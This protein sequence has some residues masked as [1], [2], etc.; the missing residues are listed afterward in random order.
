[1]ISSL[2]P[3]LRRHLAVHRHRYRGTSWYVVE[4]KASGRVH[5][6][7]PA[8][9]LLVGQMNGRRTVDDI[10]NYVVT[11]LGDDAPSQGEV[12]RLLSQLNAMDLLQTDIAPNPVE[13]TERFTK[14]RRARLRGSVGNP[15][16]LKLPLWDPDR[17]LE[18]SYPLVRPIF[19]G[20]GAALWILVTVPALILVAMH[21]SQL[22]E[23]ISDRVF[24]ME[25]LVLAAN[26]FPLLKLLHELGHGYATKIG[27]GEVHEL[28]VMFL[29]F[30]PIP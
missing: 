17:F 29:V 28:G 23:N 1:R 13:M 22:T 3:R 25:S 18:R 8:V 14:H 27:G 19:T 7:T 4:D 12:I 20:P 16:A 10:W 24:A 11:H 5:R 15:L 6:F 30:A 2:K 9:Y 21:W 26:V